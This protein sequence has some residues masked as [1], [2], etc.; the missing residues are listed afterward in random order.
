M[1]FCQGA[2]W[3]KEIQVC[4]SEVP[5]VTN[6]FNVPHKVKTWLFKLN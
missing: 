6:G 3:D 5:G 4:S 1:N 2:L